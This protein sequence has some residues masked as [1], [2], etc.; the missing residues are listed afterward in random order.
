MSPEASAGRIHVSDIEELNDSVWPWDL[1]MHQMSR[2]ELRADLDF[3][4]VNGILLTHERWSRRVYATGATPR[5]YVALASSGSEK[6]FSFT[7]REIGS[8]NPICELDGADI[9]FSTPNHEEHWVIL[10]PMGQIVGLVGDELAA[11]LLRTRHAD[12]GDP[13]VI[14]HLGALVVRV[15][16]KLREHSAYRANDLLLNAIESQLLGAI[17][18]FLV[19]TSRCVE[20]ETPRKRF[21]ACRRALRYAEKLKRPISVD[22]LAAQ[23]CVSRRSLELGFRE[24]L[25]IS[26]QR[27]LRYMRLNGLHRDLR[28]AS[29]E[30]TTVTEA[31]THWGFVELGRTAVEYRE[32]FGEPPSTTLARSGRLDCRRL[33]DALAF[34]SNAQR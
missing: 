13:R 20:H 12:S 34:S 24:T 2:G 28:R 8:G 14:R 22:E 18:E 29:S 27:Y 5:G 21:L 11:A 31:A 23:A 17:T 25:D 19:S 1:R 9:E 16:A 7:G 32:L 26:P 3:A 4:Q 6:T 30:Q 15:V 33:A 10:V